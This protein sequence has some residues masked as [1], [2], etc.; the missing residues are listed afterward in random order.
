MLASLGRRAGSFV[1]HDFRQSLVLVLASQEMFNVHVGERAQ[2]H[3]C[4]DPVAYLTPF[5]V[6]AGRS[7]GVRESYGELDASV[8]GLDGIIAGVVGGGG[9]G[10]EEV[11]DGLLFGF[12]RFDGVA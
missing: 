10:V 12:L 9:D 1:R 5:G 6:L 11:Y 8:E 2:R 4:G 3:V 7:V